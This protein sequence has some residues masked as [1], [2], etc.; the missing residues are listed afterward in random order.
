MR[1]EIK[2]IRIEAMEGSPCF[3]KTEYPSKG[4]ATHVMYTL[5]NGEKYPCS[6]R[7]GKLKDLKAKLALLPR[8]VDNEIVVI[9]HG[10]IIMTKTSMRIGVRGLEAN[11]V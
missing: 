11:P 10:M 8:E 2:V 7:A 3:E 4:Y 1:E 9:E 6:M 5:E